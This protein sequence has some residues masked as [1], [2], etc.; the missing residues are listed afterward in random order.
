MRKHA[1]RAINAVR[2]PRVR[3]AALHAGANRAVLARDGNITQTDYVAVCRATFTQ[4]VIRQ[5]FFV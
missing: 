4:F 2:R 1:Q 3:R 5:C